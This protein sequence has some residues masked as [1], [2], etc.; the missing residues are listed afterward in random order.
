M[1]E[2]KGKDKWNGFLRWRINDRIFKPRVCVDSQTTTNCYSGKFIPRFV[3]AVWKKRL[4]GLFSHSS[5]R[6]RGR[7]FLR[8]R[9]KEKRREIPSFL[10]RAFAPSRDEREVGKRRRKTRKKSIE[11]ALLEGIGISRLRF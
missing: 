7:R 10:S 8:L 1:D 6:S 4:S 2:R 9:A 11:I 3:F 5:P